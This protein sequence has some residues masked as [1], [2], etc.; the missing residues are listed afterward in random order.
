MKIE[1]I[2]LICTIAITTVTVVGVYIALKTYPESLK[3]SIISNTFKM[4]EFVQQH[5]TDKYIERFIELL[6]AN[7]PLNGC[8]ENEFKFS[9]GVISYAEDMFSKGGCGNGEVVN[10]IEVLNY[11]SKKLLNKELDEDLIWFEY[12]QI[13]TNC[14]KWVKIQYEGSLKIY[15]NKEDIFFYYFYR[16]MLKN[17]EK[18]LYKLSKVYWHCE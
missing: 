1:I 9:N 14:Y 15:K 2:N 3:Q 18:M 10:I 12:G 7:N 17:Q 6:N 13:M 8:K 5:I 11:I 4:L 16:Y